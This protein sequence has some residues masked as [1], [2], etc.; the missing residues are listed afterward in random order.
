MNIKLHNTISEFWFWSRLVYHFQTLINQ[1]GLLYAI[2]LVQIPNVIVYG[3]L[4]E[5]VG[6]TPGM[7]AC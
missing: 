1:S 3:G 6:L 4:M 7:K 2:T 5:V